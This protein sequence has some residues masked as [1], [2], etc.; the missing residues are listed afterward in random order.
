M[1]ANYQNSVYSVSSVRIEYPFESPGMVFGFLCPL[2]SLLPSRKESNMA[3]EIR[4]VDYFYSMVPDKPG[5]AARVLAGLRDAG[6]NLTAFCGFPEGRKGQLDFIPSD[7]AAFVKEAKKQGITI[8]R[9]KT[10]FLIQGDDYTGAAAEFMERLAAAKINV[11]SM[12]AISSGTGRFGAM[13]W[14]KP[15][16]VRKAAKALGVA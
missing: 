9:K 5:E 8:S 2:I 14:V 13:L 1:E 7:P 16:D 11:V 10:G 4:K 12:Q 6:L 15:V 3:S